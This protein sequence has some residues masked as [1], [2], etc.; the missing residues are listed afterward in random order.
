MNNSRPQRDIEIT[1]PVLDEEETIKVNVLILL[2]FLRSEISD[3]ASFGIVIADNGSND[4][5]REFGLELESEYAEVSYVR[6]DQKGVG[7]AL[8]KSWDSSNSKIVGYLDLDMATDLKHIRQI[9]EPLLRGNYEIATGTRLSKKSVVTGRSPI[10]ATTSRVF[11]GLLKVFFKAS[12]SDGMCGFK[13]LDRN[14]YQKLKENGATNDGWFFAT[15]LLLVAEHLGYPILEVPISW[16]DDNN[17]KVKI[18][19]LSREYLSDMSSLK[20]KLRE[21]R[22]SVG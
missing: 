5:T 4:R 9:S 2:K 6:L 16:K 12:F 11:N 1:I 19:K 7:K 21:S 10:R 14:L 3:L 8:K 15:E 20:K 18:V 17:S 22:K 13:F